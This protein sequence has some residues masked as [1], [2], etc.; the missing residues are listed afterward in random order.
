MAARPV[1]LVTTAARAAVRLGPAKPW[2]RAMIGQYRAGREHD[3]ELAERGSG[4]MLGTGHSCTQRHAP[5]GHGKA[6]SQQ[7]TS[8]GPA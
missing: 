5:A 7:V 1:R 2:S 8:G 6:A 3:A 4:P